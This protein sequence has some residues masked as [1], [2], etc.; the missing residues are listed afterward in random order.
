MVRKAIF[1]GYQRT[2][3]ENLMRCQFSSASVIHSKYRTNLAKKFLLQNEGKKRRVWHDGRMMTNPSELAKPLGKGVKTTHRLRVLNKVLRDKITDVMS[4]GKVSDELCG[5]SLEVSEVKVLPDFLG[6]NVHWM[7][8]GTGEDRQIEEVLMRNAKAIRHEISQMR[9]IGHVPPITFVKDR[10]FYKLQELEKMLSVADFGEDFVP[11]DPTHHLKSTLVL[12]TNLDSSLKATINDLDIVNEDLFEEAL[13]ISMD[14][15]SLPDEETVNVLPSDLLPMR[16]DV[17]GVDTKYIYRVVQE[18]LV[19]ARA[20]HRKNQEAHEYS[21]ST[22]EES[23]DMI[24][25]ISR[26]Q[27]IRQ[28]ANKYQ[29]LCRKQSRS[30]DNDEALL[31]VPQEWSAE[32]DD[33]EYIEEEEDDDYTGIEEF[34]FENK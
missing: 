25:S 24:N 15:P 30:K 34:D 7:C 13:K 1:L 11:T 21:L 5:V 20:E 6:I 28:W 16:N 10:R 12:K 23:S 9:V 17:F 3:L 26:T 31:S 33:I 4:T 2:V 32:S 8:T 27:E 14:S 18:R 19:R 29:Q 22:L